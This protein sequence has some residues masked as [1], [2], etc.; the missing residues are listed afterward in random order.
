MYIMVTPRLSVGLLTKLAP[1][2]NAGSLGLSV[3]AGQLSG[4]VS[5]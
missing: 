4:S 5:E 3:N 2:E 1:H